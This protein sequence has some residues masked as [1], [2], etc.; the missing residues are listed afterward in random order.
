MPG[1][2]RPR[3]AVRRPERTSSLRAPTAITGLAAVVA[4]G[5]LVSDCAAAGWATAQVIAKQSAPAAAG[6]AMVRD[7]VVVPSS[8]PFD[9]DAY[10]VS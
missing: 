4:V 8:N 9:P 10:E 2:T 6:R 1:A 5:G 3:T 7:K